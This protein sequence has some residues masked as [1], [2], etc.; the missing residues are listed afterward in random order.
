MGAM[1]GAAGGGAAA[2]PEAVVEPVPVPDGAAEGVGD[3]AMSA[4]ASSRRAGS[5]G[6]VVG[7][8]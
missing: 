4:T 7:K 8:A 6:M 2:V 5:E 3:W 1:E